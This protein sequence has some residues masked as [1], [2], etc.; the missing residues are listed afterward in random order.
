MLQVG[1]QF[2]CVRATTNLVYLIVGRC[3]GRETLEFR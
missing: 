3:N 1:T 2:V